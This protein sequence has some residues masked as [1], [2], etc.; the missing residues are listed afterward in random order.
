[1]EGSG[2]SN[3][4]A[5][6]FPV[7][8]SSPL[9]SEY[10]LFVRCCIISLSFSSYPGPILS[11]GTR[12][13]EFSSW[14]WGVPHLMGSTRMDFPV[15]ALARVALGWSQFQEGLDARL[16]ARFSHQDSCMDKLQQMVD[17]LVSTLSGKG[18][19]RRRKPSRA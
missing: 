7:I 10:T 15:E 4:L 16:E 19:W 2:S 17:R 8:L 5:V 13:L 18:S 3:Y 6:I 12:A 11:I 14:G 1:M 9:T